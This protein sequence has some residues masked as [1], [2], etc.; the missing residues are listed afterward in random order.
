M[1]GEDWALRGDLATAAGNHGVALACYEQ[2]L[3]KMAN[4]KE[5]YAKRWEDLEGDKLIE[6]LGDQWGAFAQTLAKVPMS[7][8]HLNEWKEA[9]KREGESRARYGDYG[10]AVKG[11]RTIGGLLV[12]CY[13]GIQEF[14][15]ETSGLLDLLDH[16]EVHPN[17]VPSLIMHQAPRFIIHEGKNV[18]AA[19]EACA[20]YFQ[21][22]S[23]EEIGADTLFAQGHL[24][25]KVGEVST[26]ALDE[27]VKWLDDL[28]HLDDPFDK[29]KKV[30]RL[31]GKSGAPIAAAKGVS[32][33]M[34]LASGARG[35][36]AGARGASALA[37][38][39]EALLARAFKE[40]AKAEA[41]LVPASTS[42]LVLEEGGVAALAKRYPLFSQ[43]PL[44]T[45]V[46]CDMSRKLTFPLKETSLHTG[47][48]PLHQKRKYIRQ[49][50]E[51]LNPL[52]KQGQTMK[53]VSEGHLRGLLA[54]SK[55]YLPPRPKGIPA[56]CVTKLTDRNCGIKYV[57][58][59]TANL[60]EEQQVY[61]RIMPRMVDGFP[62]QQQEYMAFEIRGKRCDRY[63]N[64]W[65]R[66][67]KLPKNPPEP[68][69][70]QAQ[71]DAYNKLKA[72]HEEW[73]KAVHCPVQELTPEMQKIFM[74]SS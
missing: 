59:A 72:A 1:T 19:W 38:E 31:I 46:A 34:K 24:L 20:D 45:E 14:I 62:C 18:V 32:A 28:H 6:Q 48:V 58:A 65:E 50:H 74:E 60:A 41:A 44:E 52:M 35:A 61:V 25:L 16:V 23:L 36:A 66:P 37:S 70:T 4:M 54:E 26:D 30:G 67:Q 55:V 12:G 9:A 33:G 7:L 5:G 63:G 8:F 42:A 11:G 57:T 10:D 73:A 53:P 56:N 15:K 64:F 68:G 49:V 43:I 27:T 40:S 39:G 71:M 2:A 47:H 29:G 69:S 51:E 3:D 17:Q 22:H 13:E 21:K